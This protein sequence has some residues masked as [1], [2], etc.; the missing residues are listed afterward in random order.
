MENQR[1]NYKPRYL[2]RSFFFGVIFPKLLSSIYFVFDFVFLEPLRFRLSPF[3]VFSSLAVLCFSFQGPLDAVSTR[4]RYQKD[5]Q[6]PP[7]LP[8]LDKNFNTKFAST[9]DFFYYE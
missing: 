1:E 9:F 6:D 4:C 7:A 5:A 8:N 3:P 2:P